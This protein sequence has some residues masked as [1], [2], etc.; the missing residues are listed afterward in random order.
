MCREGTRS[1]ETDGEGARRGTPAG[2]W[3][4][5]PPS[6]FCP[7]IHAAPTCWPGDH[8]AGPNSLPTP[9]SSASK[10]HLLAPRSAVEAPVVW[11]D[12]VFP[13]GR[14]VSCPRP[15][16][17]VVGD[18]VPGWMSGSPLVSSFER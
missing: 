18:W 13:S 8:A 7:R 9:N 16:R 17:V 3:I 2:H 12:R 14:L 10:K 11:L 15:A 5:T 6:V 4:P 1:K